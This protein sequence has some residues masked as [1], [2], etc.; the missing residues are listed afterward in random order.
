MYDVVTA[1]KSTLIITSMP[2]ESWHVTDN[3]RQKWKDTQFLY[4][5]KCSVKDSTVLKL[6]FLNTYKNIDSI[7]IKFY[8]WQKQLQ[9]SKISSHGSHRCYSLQVLS[10]DNFSLWN[11]SRNSFPF[12]RLLCYNHDTCKDIISGLWYFLWHIFTSLCLFVFNHII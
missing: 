7:L 8:E 1:A 5:L 9:L 10:P 11:I 6:I 2:W 3:L 4:L 12:S